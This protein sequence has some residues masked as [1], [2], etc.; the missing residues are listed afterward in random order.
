VE[1]R[2]NTWVGRNVSWE[3]LKKNVDGIYLAIG[4]QKSTSMG[5]DGEE[6]A[7]VGGAVEFLR[8]HNLGENPEAGKRVA[9]IGGGN[10]AIDA[11]RCVLRLGAEAVT[12]LYRRRGSDMPAQ[13]EEI[14]AAEEEGITIH[15]LAAPVR[16][17]GRNGRVGRI[18]CQRMVLGEFGSDGRRK[19]VVQAGAEFVLEVDQVIVAIG[20]QPDFS[21]AFPAADV[22]LTQHGFI[23]ANRDGRAAAAMIFAGGDA[24][25]GPDSVVHAIADGHRVAAAMDRTI[26]KKN[27]EPVYRPSPGDRIDIPMTVGEEIREAPRVRMPESDVSHRFRTFKEI[28][29]GLSHQDA[30]V[31]ADRCLRCDISSSG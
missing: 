19:P 8:A 16:L 14:H 30:R 10:S 13:K 22:Q 26:R 25:R 15:D 12:I 9:V 24:V 5:V 20:Q 1:L 21:A 23:E 27:G 4:A 29:L 3:T 7:G 28:E 18:V 11:A 31:E 17:E 6:L 2:C